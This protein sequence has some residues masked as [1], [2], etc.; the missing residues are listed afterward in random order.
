MQSLLLVAIILLLVTVHNFLSES[1]RADYLIDSQ[2][3][4]KVRDF[5][6]EDYLVDKKWYHIFVL[7]GFSSLIYEEL[8]AIFDHLLNTTFHPNLYLNDGFGTGTQQNQVKLIFD[9][10]ITN[11]KCGKHLCFVHYAPIMKDRSCLVSIPDSTRRETVLQLH[12]PFFNTTAIIDSMVDFINREANLFRELDGSL[13]QLGNILHNNRLYTIPPNLTSI[14]STPTNESPAN[15]SASCSTIDYDDILLHP[16][17]FLASYWLHQKPVIISNYP[18]TT[19]TKNNTHPNTYTCN[20]D[21]QILQLLK[22]NGHNKVGC[23]LAPSNDF[24]GIDTLLNWGMAGTQQVRSPP[25]MKLVHL[26]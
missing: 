8:R 9:K 11:P 21:A 5:S 18:I 6:T 15:P 2:S 7:C 16:E 10:R 14:P 23:K 19:S 3:D 20:I 13:T 12:Y 24:E 22:N 4:Y 1:I 17:S 26:I 25:Y